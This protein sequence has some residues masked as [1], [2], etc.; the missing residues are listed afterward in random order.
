M[1]TL[2]FRHLVFFLTLG[3]WSLAIVI[4]LVPLCYPWIGSEASWGLTQNCLLLASRKQ[5]FL[6]S[7]KQG[8]RKKKF[9]SVFWLRVSTQDY[10]RH[11]LPPENQHL[12]L[13]LPSFKDEC[14]RGGSVLA[15]GA[16]SHLCTKIPQC[17]C[18]EL[19]TWRVS[20]TLDRNE[21]PSLLRPP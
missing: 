16:I 19:K 2:K 13:Q 15:A 5:G 8:K 6:F 18:K 14:V 3:I 20:S 4:L 10:F 1:E 12:F 7:N 11:L 21:H 9:F 17:S